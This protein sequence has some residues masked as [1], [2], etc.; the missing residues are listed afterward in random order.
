MEIRIVLYP[1]TNLAFPVSSF[2]ASPFINNL[3]LYHEKK[4]PDY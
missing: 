1:Y 3:Y 2:F 4:D